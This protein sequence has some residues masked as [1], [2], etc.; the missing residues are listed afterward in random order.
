MAVEIDKDWRKKEE[1]YW[2][3]KKKY[4]TVSPFAITQI[5]VQRRGIEYT[6]AALD[7]VDPA[8]HQTDPYGERLA[9]ASLLLRRQSTSGY[10]RGKRCTFHLM[11]GSTGYTKRLRYLEKDR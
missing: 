7:K 3:I 1:S 9:P 4:P 6:D 2:E 11:S 8:I 5:D 10:A